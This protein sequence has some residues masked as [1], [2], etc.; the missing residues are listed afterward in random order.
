M[1]LDEDPKPKKDEPA[2]KTVLDSG[3]NTSKV[4]RSF[5]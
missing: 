3:A 1:D 4:R 2:P 5:S